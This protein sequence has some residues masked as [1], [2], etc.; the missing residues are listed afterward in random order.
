MTYLFFD[1][2]CANNFGGIGKMCSFGYV[3][4]REDFS[5]IESDDILMNP[6]APFDWY[7]FKSGSKCQ[8]AYRREDYTR[9]PSFAAHYE[10][11][12][13]LLSAPERLV[14]GFGCENDVATITT[15]CVRYDRPLI[16]FACYDI[17]AA[18]MAHY[19]QQGK[20]SDYVAQLG[21]DTTGL[22]FHD[23][24]ADALFTMKVTEAL[25]TDSKQTLSERLCAYTPITSAGALTDRRQKLYRRHLERKEAANVAAT[26]TQRRIPKRVTVPADFDFRSEL[27]R[28]LQRQAAGNGGR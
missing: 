17:R 9:Q 23:S 24:R 6:D 16:T 5:V 13:G 19:H 1:I 15:E 18:L 3:L 12:C 7:L 11:L 25:C 27:L 2:E 8:L 20:L 10:R 21:I 22:D 14:V 26:G 4:C 28:E